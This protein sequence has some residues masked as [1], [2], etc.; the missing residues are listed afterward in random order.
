MKLKSAICLLL[1][2]TVFLGCATNQQSDET[3]QQ[4]AQEHANSIVKVPIIMYHHMSPKTRLR[5]TYTISP[6]A[7]ETDLQWLV[8]HGYEAVF[9]SEIIDYVNGICDLP[10]KPVVISFDDG[11]E[12]FFTYAL[13]LLEK[14]N[15]CAVL[16]IIGSCAEQFSNQPDHNLDYS[17]MSWE[18]IRQAHDSGIVEI[19]NHSF[20]LH[21]LSPRCGCRILAGENCENYKAMLSSDL[22][23]LDQA[24]TEIG[25][26]TP[27]VF[28]YPFGNICPE[29]EEVLYTLGYQAALTCD[30]H[31]NIITR[32][33][34]KCLMHLGRFNRTGTAETW[35]FFFKT[36][37]ES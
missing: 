23:K 35:S 22:K 7:F 4:D 31:I 13:P 25:I 36:L 37:S 32:G 15:M 27:T 9:V 2:M 6:E 21:S 28:A 20:S 33:D 26:S 34:K 14:Y 11:Q 17:Y 16:A 30:G 8:S 1:L 24:L 18:Q 10:E 3:I 5:G 12:S 19:A 29:A